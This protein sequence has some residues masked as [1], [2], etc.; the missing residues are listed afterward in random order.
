[1]NKLKIEKKTYRGTLG[2]GYI[3]S[4]L[5]KSELFDV[6]YHSENLK[7]QR[8][9]RAS[10]LFF[11]DRKIYLDLWEYYNPTHSKEAYNANYDLFI[12]LQHVKMDM[13]VY[14]KRCKRKNVLQH[15][16]DEEREKFYS[17]IV[18]WTFFPSTEI[19]HHLRDQ[20]LGDGPIPS[21]PE[22]HLAFFSGKK[23]KGRHKWLDMLAK[24]DGVIINPHN[25]SGRHQ[26]GEGFMTAEDYRDDMLSSK[27]GLVLAGRG[28]MLTQA[29]NRRE[30]DYMIMKKP[31]VINYE[32]YYYNDLIEGTHYILLK[33]GMTLDDLHNQYDLDAMVENAYQWYLDNATPMGVAKT[34]LQIMKS[35]FEDEP[36][37]FYE[38]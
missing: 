5:E 19:I 8:G 22:K 17:K 7:T 15:I 26:R 2:M 35:E 30:I 6:E 1:M 11:N 10:T 13:P 38:I 31:F 23:W 9:E 18:P 33:D 21:L 29:K 28:S 32:P 24:Q 25:G 4:S 36:P 14:H 12:K 20:K 37:S 16:T 34:F 27:Y 3:L